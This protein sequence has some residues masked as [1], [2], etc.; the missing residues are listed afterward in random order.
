MKI[1]GEIRRLVDIISTRGSITDLYQIS[2]SLGVH[3]DMI[4]RRLWQHHYDGNFKGFFVALDYYL[5][6]SPKLCNMLF[7]DKQFLRYRLSRIAEI[8]GLQQDTGNPISRF[9]KRRVC[10]GD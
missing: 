6:C 3:L 2:G 7:K 1:D 9:R 4:S 5:N 10:E 8:L